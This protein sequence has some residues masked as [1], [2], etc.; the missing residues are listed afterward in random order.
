[1]A[2]RFQL[3]QDTFL[4]EIDGRPLFIDDDT[5]IDVI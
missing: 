4:I 5:I 3:N 2:Y 1:M